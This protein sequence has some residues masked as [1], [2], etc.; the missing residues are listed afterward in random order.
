MLCV[1][2]FTFGCSDSSTVLTRPFMQPCVWTC[3]N[4]AGSTSVNCVPT[5]I[6]LLAA[7]R[8][9]RAHAIPATC[10]VPESVARPVQGG[11]ARRARVTEHQHVLAVQKMGLRGEQKSGRTWRGL[12]E[13]V[14]ICTSIPRSICR[15]HPKQLSLCLWLHV[16]RMCQVKKEAETQFSF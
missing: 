12:P 1:C 7:G 6:Q 15:L 11:P 5:G 3:V 4:L 8:V 9:L 2:Y 16:R 10:L 13:P 14:K